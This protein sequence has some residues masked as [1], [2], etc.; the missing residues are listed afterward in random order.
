[1]ADFLLAIKGEGD[2]RPLTVIQNAWTNAHQDEAD[3][4]SLLSFIQTDMPPIFEKIIKID[5]RQN[6]G[7]SINDIVSLG[8]QIEFTNLSS[9]TLQNWVKRDVK[10]LIGSPRFGKKYTVEQAATLFIVEDLKASLDFVSIRNVLTL[11]FNNPDDQSDDIVDPIHFYAAYASIFE[12]I[13]HQKDMTRC[14]VAPLNMQ[15]EM[16]IKE[17]AIN[18]LE[19]FRDLTT[20]QKDIILHLLVMSSLTV[21]SAYY[22]TITKKYTMNT[23]QI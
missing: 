16:L 18:Q 3:T 9:T 10:G 8:N 19:N 22:Q 11:I 1:M 23:L 20:H 13:H 17:E 15:I 12:K 21:L 6:I 2:N 14:A 7:F 4:R 5:G